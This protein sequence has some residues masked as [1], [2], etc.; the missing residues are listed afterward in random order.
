MIEKDKKG[1]ER[2]RRERGNNWVEIIKKK[3]D[4]EERDG[5]HNKD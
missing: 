5:R 4:C 1:R 3:E 2:E